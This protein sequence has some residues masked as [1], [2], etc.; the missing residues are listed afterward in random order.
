MLAADP[1]DIAAVIRA[2]NGYFDIGAYPKAAEAYG[3][4]L[5]LDPKNAD[6]LTDFGV[7]L[8]R[9]KKPEQAA[10]KFREA[11][12]ID[13]GHAVALFNLGIVLRDDLKNLPEALR[14]WETFLEKAGNAPHAV[15][16]RPWVEKLRKKLNAKKEQGK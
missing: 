16:V 6:I 3:K 13:P 15:M 5:A 2:A 12:K 11:L 7:C 1:N 4:A 9:M 8:R 14:T 10:A